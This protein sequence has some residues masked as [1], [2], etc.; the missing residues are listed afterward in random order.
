M[1]C[2]LDDGDQR[3]VINE[4]HFTD[5]CGSLLVARVCPIQHHQWPGGGNAMHPRQICR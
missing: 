5:L 2:C 4:L 1:K 3:A